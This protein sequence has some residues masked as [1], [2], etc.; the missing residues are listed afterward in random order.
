VIS[1]ASITVILHLKSRGADCVE[2]QVLNVGVFNPLNGSGRNDGQIARMHLPWFGTFDMGPSASGDDQ[3]T[4]CGSVQRMG[5]GALTGCHPGPGDGHLRISAAIPDFHDVT[6]FFK[7][8]KLFPVLLEHVFASHLFSEG[9]ALVSMIA[10]VNTV[11]D[12]LRARYIFSAGK[13]HRKI[14]ID[15][16][17]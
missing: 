6:V 8:F 5:P 12:R 1:L 7:K 17:D 2:D 15:G 11:D 9:P 14:K 4:L 10:V 3:V 13:I 16:I